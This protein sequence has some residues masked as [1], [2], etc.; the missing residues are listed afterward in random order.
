MSHKVFNR[1]EVSAV[2]IEMGA[3][4]MTER[5]AGEA[6]LPARGILMGAHMAHDVKG[7]NRAG[8]IRLFW[9][10]PS[11]WPVVSKPVFGKDVQGFL[12]KDGITVRTVFGM[13]DMDAHIFPLN[14]TITQTADFADSETGRIHE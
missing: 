12:G 7:I 5:M 14:V 1:Q 9:E 13:C 3:K 6:V 8:R 11:G 4:G 2:F 10:K